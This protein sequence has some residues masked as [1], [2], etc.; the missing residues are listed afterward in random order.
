[1]TIRRPLSLV[2]L[3]LAGTAGTGCTSTWWKPDQ[4]YRLNRGPAAMNEEAYYSIPAAVPSSTEPV[5]SSPS[6]D[7]FEPFPSGR[8]PA[9]SPASGR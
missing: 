3:I 1:M 6:R 9:S 8:I 4:L 7:P 5:G 2:C